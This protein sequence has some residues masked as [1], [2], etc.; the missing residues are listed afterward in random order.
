M[1]PRD[2]NDWLV[3]VENR[4]VRLEDKAAEIAFVR[5]RLDRLEAAVSTLVNNV[6]EIQQLRREELQEQGR[7]VGL[8]ERQARASE[9]IEAQL[10]T[11]L[12]SIS[13]HIQ[14]AAFDASKAADNTSR[15]KLVK[16]DED[17]KQDKAWIPRTAQALHKW[18]VRTWLG[19]IG[20][21]LALTA[22]G[23]TF[24]AIEIA[25]KPPPAGIRKD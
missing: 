12:D 15:I 9:G 2:T 11:R 13:S 17:S 10:L 5:D 24:Y 20:T 4:I 16:S 7:L 25:R 23:W 8:V 18:Q 1:S 6:L 3:A 21:L 19:I 14:R 22:L